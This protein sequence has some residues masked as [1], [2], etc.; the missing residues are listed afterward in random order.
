[1]KMFSGMGLWNKWET[2]YMITC[3]HFGLDAKKTVRQCFKCASHH[4]G[5]LVYMHP[6]NLESG[7]G[8][9]LNV[10]PLLI[11]EFSDYPFT[12]VNQK[13]SP[14]TLHFRL[15][16]LKSRHCR[17]QLISK[18]FSDQRDSIQINWFCL[19][20]IRTLETFLFSLTYFICFLT[21]SWSKY[22]MHLH[23]WLGLFGAVIFVS[24][25]FKK[26]CQHEPTSLKC[27]PFLLHNFY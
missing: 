7:G 15:I 19:K 2:V 22:I 3:F 24:Y 4:G 5:L 25:C 27:N 23:P 18:Q 12:V 1:M 14:K 17:H 6:H 16:M 26:M 9:L 21:F 10:T 8:F 20:C 11:P 13:L